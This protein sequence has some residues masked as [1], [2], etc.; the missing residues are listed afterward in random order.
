MRPTWRTPARM[1]HV[2]GLL[3]AGAYLG[4]T[5]ACASAWSIKVARAEMREQTIA[6]GRSMAQIANAGN[7][8]VTPLVMNGERMMIASSVTEDSARAV[9]DRYE[10]H[11]KT[12]GGAKGW[13]ELKKDDATAAFGENGLVRAGDDDEGSV[14]CFVRGA[15]TNATVREAFETFARTGEL[16]HLGKVRYAYARKNPSSGRTL[17]LTA[18]TEDSFNL[19]D[20]MPEDGKDVRGDDFADIPRP[21]RSSRALAVRAEGL[22]YAL[23]V[24]KTS[25]GPGPVL[26]YYDAEMTRRGYRGFDPEEPTAPGRT[27]VKDGVVLTVAAHAEAGATFVALGLAGAD[28][29]EDPR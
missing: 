10:E 11:C 14:V 3:R 29:A 17:V 1:R 8:D 13:A 22:P 7:H 5:M 23:N 21:E 16:G 25:D 12:S 28:A 6:L 9:L 24:Y 19:F 4:F 18:W 26:A 15:H 27:F 20:F 2:R